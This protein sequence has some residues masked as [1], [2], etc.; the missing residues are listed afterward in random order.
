MQSA[1]DTRVHRSSAGKRVTQE[2]ATEYLIKWVGWADE[3]NTWEAADDVGEAAIADFESPQRRKAAKAPAKTQPATS[4]PT[5]SPVA[6][7]SAASVTAFRWEASLIGCSG[8]A[9]DLQHT[10]SELCLACHVGHAANSRGYA[11]DKSVC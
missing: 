2:G 5:S 1:N 11:R 10:C 3:D 9:S 7:A 4:S 6:A 8:S